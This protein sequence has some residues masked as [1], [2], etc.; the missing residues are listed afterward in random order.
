M[1]QG[2]N[3]HGNFE[4]YLK[5]ASVDLK[6]SIVYAKKHD[7]RNDY[8]ADLEDAKAKIDEVLRCMNLGSQAVRS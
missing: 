4:H 5:Q 3:H 1:K 7:I 2:K 6:F 8:V